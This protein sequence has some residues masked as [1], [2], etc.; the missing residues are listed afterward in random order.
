MRLLSFYGRRLGQA[1]LTLWAAY[2]LAFVLLSALPGD[3]ISNRA[4]DP[5][6]RLTDEEAAVLHTY[7]GTDR[8]ISVQYVRSLLGA[9]RGDLGY[10]LQTAQEVTSLIGQALPKT[11]ALTAVALA[12]AVLFTAFIGIVGNYA[13]WRFVRD[14]VGAL[15]L[16]FASV[17]TFVVG[18]V[19]LQVFSFRWGLIPAID[20]GSVL[21]LIAPGITLGILVS[22]SLGQV[23]LHSVRQTRKQ[24]FIGVAAARGLSARYLFGRS[25]LRNSSLPVLTLLGLAVGELIAGTV[26]TEAVFARHGIGGLL[27]TAVQTQDLPVVQG[28]VLVSAAAFVLSSLLVD[29]LYPLID[30]RILQAPARR[31]GGEDGSPPEARTVLAPS[32]AGRGSAP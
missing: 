8:P 16:V 2:T 1:A 19:L 14:A 7:Y 4:N 28:V 17:P 15:P 24:P 5:A 9:L 29:L 11:L 30:P 12:F 6:A 31:H 20:D 21:A 25:V 22:A 32:T 27:L 26:I 10:S 23:F 3:A 18:V 13:R